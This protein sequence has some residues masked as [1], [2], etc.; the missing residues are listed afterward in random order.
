[1]QTLLKGAVCRIYLLAEMEYNIYKCS[2]PI[3]LEREGWGDWYSVGGNLTSR[4]YTLDLSM[5]LCQYSITGLCGGSASGKTT[6]A[7]KI[8]EALDVPWVVLLS[9]DSF[10]KVCLYNKSI[11]MLD[12]T[13]VHTVTCLFLL[14]PNLRL[15][16]LLTP[17]W[18]EGRLGNSE[19]Q[20]RENRNAFG[21]RKENEDKRS[22]RRERRWK[23]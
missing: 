7:R 8:I 13:R 10:Y 3:R 17:Q 5:S 1:M 23:G 14:L 2:S 21:S 4:S 11:Q 20:D 18:P 12:I 16:W 6:V 22:D 15:V 9:M 19:L